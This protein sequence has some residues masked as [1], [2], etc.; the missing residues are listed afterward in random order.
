MVLTCVSGRAILLLQGC[1]AGDRRGAMRRLHVHVPRGTGWVR[2]QAAPLVLVVP[3]FL[4]CLGPAQPPSMEWIGP[5]PATIV[6]QPDD[7]AGWTYARATRS[8]LR[9]EDGQVLTDEYR[10]DFTRPTPTG[11]PQ[12][13][14]ATVR[15]YSRLSP[16]GPAHAAEGV[17]AMASTA[18]QNPHAVRFEVHDLGDAAFGRSVPPAPPGPWPSDFT[19]IIVGLRSVIVELSVWNRSQADLPADTLHELA[20][21]M[22]ERAAH[23][24]DAAVFD[25][26]QPFAGNP[27]PWSYLLTP[28]DVGPNWARESGP[29]VAHHMPA[30]GDPERLD[31]EN[32]FAVQGGRML[33]TVQ[34]YATVE[35][36]VAAVDEMIQ[37]RG[38]RRVEMP[39]LGD[40]S[41]TMWSGVVQG[42]DAAI[43]SFG[44]VEYTGYDVWVRRGAV[45]TRVLLHGAP[46]R[47]SLEEAVAL[48]RQADGKLAAGALSRPPSTASA[49]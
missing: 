42:S 36:A 48:A 43:G 31:A 4:A 16:S 28:D 44:A 22:V 47:V 21:L 30:Q 46:H 11:I 6:L 7:L 15:V 27:R 39:P 45:I 9:S 2:R 32:E 26:N 19:E 3:V 12:G 41:A 33:S 18:E 5:D 24:E 34:V 25:W 10:A 38:D 49:T 29:I 37:K 23:A 13:V 20:R 17:L 8:A 35:A 14:Q 1:A 40:Q